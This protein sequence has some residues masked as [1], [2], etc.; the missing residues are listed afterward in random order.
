MKNLLLLGLALMTIQ[1]TFAREGDRRPE[2]NKGNGM[3]LVMCLKTL[4]NAEFKIIELQEQLRRCSGNGSNNGDIQRLRE[5]NSRLSYDNSNLSSTN[6]R[7]QEENRDL[8]R[9][10]DMSRPPQ[11]ATEVFSYAACTNSKGK[12]DLRYVA[13][14]SASFRLE[15]EAN[16]LKAVQSK[17]GCSYAAVIVESAPVFSTQEVNYC[18]AACLNSTGVPDNRYSVGARG[19]NIIEAKFNVLKATQS[20]FGCSYG[21]EVQACE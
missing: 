9:Q 11:Q 17:Y 12:A 6:Y 8:R 16:A 13:S 19:R 21:V 15:A 7:L 10:L 2:F 5:E 20:K 18:T 14:G 1:P 3:D 4:N